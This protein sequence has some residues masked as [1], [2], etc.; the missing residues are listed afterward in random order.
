[1]ERTL[2]TTVEKKLKIMSSL[3]AEYV[4]RNSLNKINPTYNLSR[5]KII[6][7]SHVRCSCRQHMR[8]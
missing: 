7:S 6:S 5:V 1:M 8:P 4:S 2:F 3:T